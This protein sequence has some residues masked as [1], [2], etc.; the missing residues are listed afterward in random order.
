MACIH[1]ENYLRTPTDADTDTDTDADTHAHTHAH[2]HIS[3]LRLLEGG[4]GGVPR[5]KGL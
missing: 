2:T 1:I 3:L 4:E 5:D